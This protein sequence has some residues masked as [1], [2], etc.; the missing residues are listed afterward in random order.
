[1]KE[2]NMKNSKLMV[3]VIVG[4]AVLTFAPTVKGE[5]TATGEDGITASPKVRAELNDRAARLTTAA[6]AAAMACATCKDEYVKRTDWTVKGATKPTVIVSK[7]LCAGCDTSTTVAGI[8]K[9]KHNVV[10]HKC[11]L[12]KTGK[13]NCCLVAGKR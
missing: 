5:Y 11:S 8:G 2:N 13:A 4:A 3:A 9:A 12:D 1:M 10:T 7:H 6:P